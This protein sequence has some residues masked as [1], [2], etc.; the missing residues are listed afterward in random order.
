MELSQEVLMPEVDV[1]RFSPT[2]HGSKR[3][4]IQITSRGEKWAT[5]LRIWQPPTDLYETPGSYVIQVEIAGMQDGE[6]QVTLEGRTVVISG[7][8]LVPNNAHAYFQMEIPSGEFITTVELPGAVDH[9]QIEAE[10]GD[11]FLKIVLPKAQASQVD[12]SS[13]DE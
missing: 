3:T 10:Y 8:R 6:F 4:K 9:E 2:Q 1:H 13:R 5:Y 11:G 12:V 7:S